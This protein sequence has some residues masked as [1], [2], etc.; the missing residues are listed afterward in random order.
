M[1]V[2]SYVNIH[3]LNWFEKFPP[4]VCPQTQTYRPPRTREK[5]PSGCVMI[6]RLLLAGRENCRTYFIFWHVPDQDPQRTA[7]FGI[8]MRCHRQIRN[9]AHRATFFRKYRNYN[10]RGNYVQNQACKRANDVVNTRNKKRRKVE[11]SNENVGKGG[12]RS[13]YL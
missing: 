5:L 9:V 7:Q 8:S 11:S 12:Y 10:H 1:T 6:G 3:D 13:T 4:H 2:L